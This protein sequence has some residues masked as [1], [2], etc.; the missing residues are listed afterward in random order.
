M[1]VLFNFH[2][3]YNL[4]PEDEGSAWNHEDEVRSKDYN[5][6]YFTTYLTLAVL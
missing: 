6:E 4:S 3:T 1:E 5:T 2:M